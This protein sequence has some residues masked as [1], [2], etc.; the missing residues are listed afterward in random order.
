MLKLYVEVVKPMITEKYIDLHIHSTFS[1]GTL[2]PREIVEKAAKTG[3]KAIAL[4]DHDNVAGVPLA[5][6]AGKEF[7]VEVISGAEFAAYYPDEKGTEIHIVGLF[8]N[9]KNGILIDKTEK[10]LED[11]RQR[12]I[13]MIKKLQSIGFDITYDELTAEA[14][15]VSY[16]RAHFANILLKKGYVKTKKEAFEKYIGHGKPAFVPR[17]LPSPKECIDIIRLSGGISVLAHPTLYGLNYNQIKS[18]AAAL[19]KTGL[20]AIEVMYSTYKPEQEREIKKIAFQT[21]LGFSGGSDF[22]GANKPDISIGRGRGNLKIP[23]KFLNELKALRPQPFF[24]TN[25]ENMQ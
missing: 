12:N 7:D 21:G 24:D 10:I 18:M 15:G 19:K 5:I 8:I 20:S 23:E 11:R 2:T 14:G 22:H 4:T 9:H 25:A 16:S 6:E 1:D 17:V 3:L 13:E